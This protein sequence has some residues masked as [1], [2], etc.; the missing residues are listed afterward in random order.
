MRGAGGGKTCG[1]GEFEVDVAV[2]GAGRL[3]EAVLRGLLR[4]GVEQGRLAASTGSRERAMVLSAELGVAV[5][6]DDGRAVHG[7]AVVL[8]A[9]PPGPVP[10]VLEA[11]AGRLAP[12]A[13]VVSLAAG[14][15]LATLA[16][17]L[18]DGVPVVRAMTNVAVALDAGV[19]A[20]SAPEGTASAVRDRI[21]RLFGRL[22]A[23]TWVPE[24]EQP[25]VTAVAGS[26][27]AY[28]YYVADALADAAIGEGLDPDT[29][30]LLV[31][32]T[33]IGAAA[34]LHASDAAP[35]DLLATVATPGGTTRA[36]VDRLDQDGV[37]LAFRRAVRAAVGRAAPAEGLPPVLRP[38]ATLPV[39]RVQ[40]AARG[41]WEN[42][43]VVYPDAVDPADLDQWLR[44]A[45]TDVGIEVCCTDEL[46]LGARSADRAFLHGIAEAVAGGR[47][48]TLADAPACWR[49]PDGTPL[50]RPSSPETLEVGAV[51]AWRTVGSTVIWRRG[52]AE[53]DPS[54]VTPELRA[55]RTAPLALEAGWSRPVPTWI[56]VDVSQSVH[57][58]DDALLSAEAATFL[59]WTP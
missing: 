59:T 14:V 44:T 55:A 36:A 45:G 46:F 26:G 1:M 52:E 38:R 32:R 3:G 15:P 17:A 22:G 53:P 20:L 37:P 25:V 23:V 10:Q 41:G 39:T 7:A 4:A 28:L 42:P 49:L 13:V 50:L 48:R 51:D 19:T 58:L 54:R 5:G 2:V 12:G 24:D 29:A 11:V 27:P 6:Q 31:T 30:R 35:G 57:R 56:G 9:V 16:A 18:P 21:E 43:L 40:I 33:L 47:W 34:V 8:V